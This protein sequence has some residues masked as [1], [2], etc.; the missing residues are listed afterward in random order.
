[1]SQS[2]TLAGISFVVGV[3]T[4]LTG[5]GGGAV[6]TPALILLGIPPLAAVSNDLVAS[7]VIKPFGAV[8]HAGRRTV[9][10]RLLLWLS[11]GSV[12]CGFIGALVVTLI[13][14]PQHANAVVKALVGA[15]LALVAVLLLLRL[16]SSRRTP[17]HSDEPVR[18]RRVATVALGAA[19]GLLVGMTSIGSGSA[20]AA[21]LLLLYRR[22][23][24]A[25]IVGTDVAHAIPLVAS[26]TAGHLLFGQVHLSLA[27]TLVGGGVPGV[28]IG[29]YLTGRIPN[30]ALR[31]GLAVLLVATA[32]TLL[33][34]SIALVVAASAAAAALAATMAVVR[35]PGQLRVWPVR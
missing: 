5:V 25:R 7:L 24:A 34:S 3:L 6:L 27:V 26:A 12:P 17:A 4:G 11:V 15:T 22:L 28:L 33:S 2:L 23:P 35:A 10:P 18:V 1:M 29:S 32:T 19:A 16:H 21:G 20:V 30:N 31:S 9:E 14:G 8:V 13:P